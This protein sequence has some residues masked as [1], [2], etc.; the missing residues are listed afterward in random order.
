L[1][2]K[3]DVEYNF[4]LSNWILYSFVVED[5]DLNNSIHDEL[6][7]V[8]FTRENTPVIIKSIIEFELGKMWDED[9]NDKLDIIDQFRIHFKIVPEDISKVFELGKPDWKDS[10]FLVKFSLWE[11]KLQA[12]YDIETHLLTKIS[13]V[14]CDKT[15][16]IRNLTI[17]I[18]T[19]NESKLIEI[20]NNP[21]VFFAQAN[22]AAYKK[23]QRMC[24]EDKPEENKK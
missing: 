21:R 17:E 15:L 16:E 12:N 14:A 4:M 8:M 7:F 24:N 13:Y 5:E 10:K 2:Y 22:P 6:L 19:D 18:S 11:F 20:L 9:I 1:L 3:G 23:Y